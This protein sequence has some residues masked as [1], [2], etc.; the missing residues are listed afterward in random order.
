MVKLSRLQV[1]EENRGKA[2]KN[3]QTIII[4]VKIQMN[5]YPVANDL[6]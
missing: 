5:L 2:I 4:L 3:T 1:D 6:L